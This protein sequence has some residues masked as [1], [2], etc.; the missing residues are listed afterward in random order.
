MK[1]ADFIK[2]VGVVPTTTREAVIIANRFG[3]SFARRNSLLKSWFN[4]KSKGCQQPGSWNII[5]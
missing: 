1:K 5:N 4:V 3:I 2:T